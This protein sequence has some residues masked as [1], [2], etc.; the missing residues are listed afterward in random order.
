M[1]LPRRVPPL[2]GS[3]SVSC[4]CKALMLSLRA[5]I[6]SSL[7]L[8]RHATSLSPIHVAYQ[9]GY[10]CVNSFNADTIIGQVQNQARIFQTSRLR[11]LIHNS[12]R[13][14]IY[15]QLSRSFSIHI[16]SGMS[17]VL[18]V[19]GGPYGVNNSRIS[20]RFGAEASRLV[21]M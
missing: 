16:S 5:S 20:F 7:G 19:F 17:Y 3:G 13:A 2:D 1:A 6:T 9:H 10:V 14:N 15:L 18:L 21:T 4:S 11:C 12:D 8:N